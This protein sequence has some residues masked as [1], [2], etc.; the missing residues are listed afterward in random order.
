MASSKGLASS[1]T[2]IVDNAG[3]PAAPDFQVVAPTTCVCLPCR[4][5]RRSCVL[6]LAPPLGAAHSQAPASAAHRYD[7]N[8]ACGGL[9][10]TG[11]QLGLPPRTGTYVSIR[12]PPL[13]GMPA[14]DGPDQCPM[15]ALRAARASAEPRRPGPLRCCRVAMLGHAC[16]PC[17]A[18]AAA[19]S[20]LSSAVSRPWITR[21][22]QRH[23]TFRLPPRQPACVP[24]AAGNDGRAI[25]LSRRP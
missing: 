17:A 9:A 2:P 7:I 12:P 25:S 19:M 13:D 22:R 14:Q 3:A 1:T 10:R 6:T 5:E 8:H 24:R 23:R 4:R 11:A 18:H 21:G 15:S 16:R 20:A